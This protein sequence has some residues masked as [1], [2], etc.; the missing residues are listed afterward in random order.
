MKKILITTGLKETWDRS[1]DILGF[2]YIFYATS[3]KN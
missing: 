2:Y 3:E 1:I